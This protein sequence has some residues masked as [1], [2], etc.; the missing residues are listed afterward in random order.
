MIQSFQRVMGI[1]NFKSYYIMK[2][3]RAISMNY[4]KLIAILTGI[5]LYI[6]E[7]IERV[8]VKEFPKE[9]PHTK[10][11]IQL[12]KNHN[13]G[14]PFGFMKEQKNLILLA[15][16][17]V[18]SALIGVFSYIMR[19][20]G[21]ALE[22]IGYSFAIGGGLSNLYDRFTRKYVVDYFSIQVSFLKKVVFNL[23]DIF[24][25]IGMIIILTAD[26]VKESKNKSS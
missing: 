1:T 13:D 17:M 12:H 20:P 5:D 4:L 14:L 16:L 2:R 19:T 6:K 10:G 23:G 3:S 18:I 15:P 21:N 9:L 26:V 24:V 8:E 7:V 25:F 22:K 11:L